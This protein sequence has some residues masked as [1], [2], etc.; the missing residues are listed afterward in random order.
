MLLG[1][2]NQFFRKAGIKF[3]SDDKI[4]LSCKP[5]G[6]VEANEIEGLDIFDPEGLGI[7][8]ISSGQASWLKRLFV[9]LHP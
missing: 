8:H 9:P 2:K 3:E 5:E 4:I 7:E 1:I 6:I